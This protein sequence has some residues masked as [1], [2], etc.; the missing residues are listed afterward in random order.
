MNDL[1]EIIYM[2]C[3][4]QNSISS[5]TNPNEWE[6]RIGNEALLLPKGSHWG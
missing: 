4:R 3:N 5:S 2:D 1:T 6:Y